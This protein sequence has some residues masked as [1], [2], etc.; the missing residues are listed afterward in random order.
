MI[1]E[2]LRYFSE[3]LNR[4][5]LELAKIDDGRI[6]KKR[7]GE[8]AIRQKKNEEEKRRTKLATPMTHW[9]RANLADFTKDARLL[10]LAEAVQKMEYIANVVVPPLRAAGI[11]IPEAHSAGASLVMLMHDEDNIRG[12]INSVTRANAFCCLRLWLR[13]LRIGR[14][15]TPSTPEWAVAKI[16]IRAAEKICR[17]KEREHPWYRAEMDH[18]PIPTLVTYTKARPTRVSYHDKRENETL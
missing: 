7:A 13:F 1:L 14:M 15:E 5:T 9:V 2:V 8:K 12:S 16:A 18:F 3:A 17:N 4:V 11:E 6:P 10:N